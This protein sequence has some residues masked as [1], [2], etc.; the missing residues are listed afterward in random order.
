MIESKVFGFRSSGETKHFVSPGATARL[1]SVSFDGTQDKVQGKRMLIVDDDPVVESL[2]TIDSGCLCS[3]CV[4]R[5]QPANRVRKGAKVALLLAFLAL[6]VANQAAAALSQISFN[7]GQGNIG[8]GLID[9]AGANNIYS[10]M[11]GYLDVTGGGAA[12]HWVL[13]AAGGATAYPN[14][15]TSPAGAYWYNNAVY[16]TG[17]NPQYPGV[18]VLLDVYGLL[19][20][21]TTG[22]N[23]LNLWGNADRSYNLA[24]NINGWQNFNVIISPA[25]VG[26]SSGVIISH[27][28]EASTLLA[29]LL[30]LVVMSTH[31]FRS[32]RKNRL[33]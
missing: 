25:G 5:L 3:T 23:E 14:F 32:L 26:G 2:Q 30:L 16:P 27:A 18:S 13:Y 29:P 10:A 19:F 33:I 11:S 9:I 6:G 7:D 21:Q 31:F 12:G 4:A 15:L 22:N 24:G 28:P 17:V 20:R 8:S 1:T